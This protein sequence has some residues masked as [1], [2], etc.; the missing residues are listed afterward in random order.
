MI[1]K[2]RSFRIEHMLE[3]N[4]LEHSIPQTERIICNRIIYAVDLHRKTIKCVLALKVLTLDIFLRIIRE[5]TKI[6]R[7]DILSF[8]FNQIFM[9]VRYLFQPW[10][11]RVNLYYSPSLNVHDDGNKVH[12]A[13]IIES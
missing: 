13:T 1:E 2:V 6:C 7:C 11:N 4:V 8:Q 10:L 12:L 9:T 5:E 3:R